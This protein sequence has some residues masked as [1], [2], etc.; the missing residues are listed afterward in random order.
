MPL[1][2]FENSSTQE[3]DKPNGSL[4][5]AIQDHHKPRFPSPSPFKTGLQGCC[6]RCGN[7]PLFKGVLGVANGCASC[8]LSYD[9]ADS[10]DGPMVFVILLLG[11]VILGGAMVSIFSW[12]WSLWLAV[13]F[14][15]SVTIGLCVWSLRK[16]K[17]LLIA[18]QFRNSAQEGRLDV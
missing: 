5:D 4:R 8:G 16:L 2:H 17:G 18:L 6:P 15:S 3:S 14:W 9:F 12:G 13:P 7:G 11:S 10:G 1:P